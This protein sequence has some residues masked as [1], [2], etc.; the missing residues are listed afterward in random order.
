MFGIVARRDTNRAFGFEES[1]FRRRRV[2][3]PLD[4]YI[5][6]RETLF[7]IPAAHFDMLEQVAPFAPLMHQRR[8][9]RACVNR[10]SDDG[11]RFVIDFDQFERT[12]RDI[13]RVRRDNGN[14]IAHVANFDTTQHIPIEMHQTMNVLTRHISGGQH[15]AHTR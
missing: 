5:R 12:I 2:I 10:I 13:L 15:C 4:N 11:Q 6:L 3:R 1:V 8:F 7:D 9:G 14:G